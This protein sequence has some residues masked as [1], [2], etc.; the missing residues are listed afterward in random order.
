ME[1]L[2]YYLKKLDEP[3]VDDYDEIGIIGGEF[4]DIE[5][6]DYKVSA[7]FYDL[8]DKI[9]DKIKEGKV[10]R[11]LITT[12]LVFDM[13]KYLEPLLKYL[14]L[15]EVLDKVL[16][17]TSYDTIYRF[18]KDDQ[19]ALWKSN[20]Q[21]LH[22]DYPELKLHT[23]MIVTQDFINKVLSD[24]LNLNTFRDIYHTEIDFIEPASGFYYKGKKDCAKDL[25]GFFPTKNS[26]IN[27]LKKATKTNQINIYT[28]LSMQL[29]SNKV[30]AYDHGRQ[31]YGDRRDKNYKGIKP[32]DPTKKY[33]M[34][35]IDSDTSMQ[36][37]VSLFRAIGGYHG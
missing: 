6:Q 21:K 12:G 3:E 31:V 2:E 32:A 20:M 24:E 30:Y 4:F 5:L 27:F 13:S 17:C 10:K 25:P 19:E 29:R 36:D 14:R 16:L 28:F 26:F 15:S 35:F 37:I 1:N 9:V 33:E 7:L 11:F 23:E 22:T 18:N 34:G 8:I